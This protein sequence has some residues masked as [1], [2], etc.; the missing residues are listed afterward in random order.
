M[1]NG[2]CRLGYK[3]AMLS[4]LVVM[5]LQTTAYAQ[6]VST[7]TT[8][9]IVVTASKTTE[10]VKQAPQAVE[11]I[12]AEDMKAL[13]ADSLITGLAMADNVNLSSASMTGNQVMIRGMETR[14]TLILVDGKRIAGE[15]AA[16]TTNS[17]TLSR[18][19]LDTVDRVEIVRGSSSALYGSDAMGGVINIITKK[20]VKEEFVVGASTGTREQNNWYR[21]STGN[22]GRW[23]VSMDARFTKVRPINIREVSTYDR[24]VR[25]SSD[26]DG[27][28]QY[29]YGP[30]QSY[31][32]TA[33]YDFKNANKNTLR[34]DANYY[35]ESLT[36]RAA[37]AKTMMFTKGG[38]PSAGMAAMAG[39]PMEGAFKSDLVY[40]RYNKREYYDN[41]SYGASLAYAGQTK[42]NSYEIRTYYN[43]L[44]KDYRMYNDVQVPQTPITVHIPVAMN[45][46]RFQNLTYNYAI[47]YPTTDYDYAKYRTWVT[48]AHDTMNINDAHTLT[49]GGEYRLVSY[50]GTR[51]GDVDTSSSTWDKTAK[52]HSL[53]SYAAFV[54]DTWQVTDSLMVQPAVR[55]EHNNQFGSNVSPRLGLTYALTDHMRLKA[56][57]GKGYKAPTISELYINMYHSAG[58]TMV[59]VMGNP[60]LEPEKS[61]S[62]D[63][64]LEGERGQSFFK[65]SY[66]KNKVTNL[67]DSKVTVTPNLMSA[68]YYNIAKADI[69]GVELTLGHHLSNRLVAKLTYNYLDATDESTG[70]RLENRPKNATTFSLIYDDHKSYGYNASLWSSHYSDY[71]YGG[72]SYSYSTWNVALT[73]KFGEKLSAFAAVDNIFDK[74][75]D[76]LNILGRVYRVGA[77]LKF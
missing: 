44:T 53:R 73:K 3:K 27:Y 66:F 48:E 20:P 76:D 34:L 7:V 21:Y 56:S 52:E 37:D 72:K 8:N 29:M 4:T 68:R 54:E 51:I 12:T 75:L 42:K 10:L 65:G 5:M 41:K 71:I 28:N 15:D 77:E 25:G 50:D 2:V 43:Q 11:V 32:L 59:H 69:S 17:Y 47:T 26:V 23:N 60:D 39:N 33:I 62:Y 6:D 36:S 58:P 13:G 49:F 45:P 67:I 70:N 57:Y 30:K 63:I 46:L 74:N 55:F 1:K 35:T 38:Y 31:N 19:S 22:Q 18:L 40:S 64:S 61:T 9:D 14:H 16:N 24:N